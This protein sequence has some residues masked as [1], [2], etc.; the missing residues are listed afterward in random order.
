MGLYGQSYRFGMGAGLTTAVKY[1]IIANVGCFVL[2]HLIAPELVY[3]LE[4]VPAW[5]IHKFTVWQL[6][7]YMFLHGAG[8]WHILIN[9][10]VLWMFGCELEREWGSKAFLLYYFICG[11]GAGLF[12]VLLGIDSEIPVV[13]ASG[14][15]YGLLMAFGLLF[16]E[17]MITF[18]IFFILP[19]HIKAKYLVMIV[20]G[21]SLF[22]GIFD[23][24][25][26]VAHFA[27]LGGMIVGFIY[28]KMDWRWAAMRKSAGSWTSSGYTPPASGK[29]SRGFG[30][31]KD[32]FRRR[33]HKRRQME[34][35]RR[36]QH[37]MNLRERVDVILDK[38]NEVG[39][40][41]LTHEEKQ[42]LKRASEF[43]GQ[44]NVRPQ[45]YGPN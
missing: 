25:S 29:S 28:L 14:A 45:D 2:Q 17:R 20:A 44:E 37:E 31:I 9:M 7:T 13:G 11:I 18:L 19:V 4:L 42:I 34:V 8:I 41:H 6:V 1:L 21:I 10:L 38:I 26:G 43:L 16:P 33:A 24:G 27:H 40:D 36:R 30:R 39:Y 22:S 23:P 15:I 35:V 3:W 12:H 5:V 32:W